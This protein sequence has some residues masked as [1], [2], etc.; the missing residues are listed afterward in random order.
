MPGGWYCAGH[1]LEAPKPCFPDAA[2]RVEPG[3]VNGVH[4]DEACH[5]IPGQAVAREVLRI[6]RKKA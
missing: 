2:E 6:F 4:P 1:A 5:A 3:S